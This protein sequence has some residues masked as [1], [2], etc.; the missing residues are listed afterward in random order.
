[1]CDRGHCQVAGEYAATTP[2]MVA[3]RKQ[4]AGTHLCPVC[5][6]VIQIDFAVVAF[7]LVTLQNTFFIAVA[8]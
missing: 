3:V 8:H 5:D 2:V 6:F 7:K 4:N 1:M